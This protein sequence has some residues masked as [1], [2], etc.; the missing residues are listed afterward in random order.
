MIEILNPVLVLG[1]LGLA[2]GILLSIASNVFAVKVDPKVEQVRS[3][4]PGANCGACGFP[5]CDGLANAIADGKAPVNACNVGGKPVAEKI[6]DIM[7]V[8]ATN[9]EKKVATVLCQGNC[10]KAKEK[11]RYEG[12]KDCRAANILQGGSK[13]CSYGCLGC[14]TCKDV[15]AFGAIEIIDGIAVINKD[16][17]TAC[18][19]CIEACPKSIIELVPYDNQFVVKCKSNDPGKEVRS[20]CSTGCIGCQI[21]VKNCPEEAISFENNLAKINYDK[22]VNCGIC[23][24]KCPTKAIYS[25]VAKDASV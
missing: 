25:N 10:D 17:C 13:A 16:K 22:C 8:N 11:Y 12:I 23:A 20:K 4:L 9:V 2:F 3:V 5:G 6:A 21:C 19:K 1:G 14:G 18:M 7:G 24:G 15:C